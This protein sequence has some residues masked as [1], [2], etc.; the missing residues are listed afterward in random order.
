[1]NQKITV[2]TEDGK[3]VFCILSGSESIEDQLNVIYFGTANPKH[4]TCVQYDGSQIALVDYYHAD[5]IAKLQVVRIEDTDHT[6]VL[7]WIDAE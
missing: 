7:Q 3:L 5:T 4:G 6:P 2:K 1:M